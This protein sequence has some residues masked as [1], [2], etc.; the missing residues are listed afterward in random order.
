ME[1]TSPSFPK[2]RQNGLLIDRVGDETI[3]YDET[4]QQAHSLN[5]PAGFVWQHSDGTHSVGQLAELLGAETG[6]EPNESVVEYAL[7]ELSRANLLEDTATDAEQSVSRRDAVRRLTLAGAATIA[8]PAVLSILAPT[9]A[10]AASGSGNQN[11]QGGN[12]NHQ[13]QNP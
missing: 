8:L 4:R 5:R 12:N 11:G 10:M 2:S 13:G 1:H 3:V 6:S 9:P 7:E